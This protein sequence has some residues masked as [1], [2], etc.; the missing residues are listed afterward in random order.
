[1]NPASIPPLLVYLYLQ[2]AIRSMGPRPSCMATIMLRRQITPVNCHLHFR[3][4][5]DAAG[6][7]YRVHVVL[8][9]ES[10]SS[11]ISEPARAFVCG[12]RSS[13]P[14]RR[15]HNE[16]EDEGGGRCSG[17]RRNSSCVLEGI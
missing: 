3:Q 4:M 13:S 8:L 7:Q 6:R 14:L 1:M 11:L 17:G 2:P 12:L 16:D 15:T 10:I 9:T 5:L